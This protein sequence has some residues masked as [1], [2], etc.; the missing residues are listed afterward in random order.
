MGCIHTNNRRNEERNE[1][2]IETIS[3]YL[4][5]QYFK[6][7]SRYLDLDRLKKENIAV[8]VLPRNHCIEDQKYRDGVLNYRISYVYNNPISTLHTGDH[9]KTIDKPGIYFV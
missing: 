3:W 9:H 1:C 4:Y 2:K 6:M 8:L 7:K 5:M